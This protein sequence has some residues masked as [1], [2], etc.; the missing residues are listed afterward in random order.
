MAKTIGEQIKNQRVRKGLT[1]YRVA[2]DLHL[3]H[4]TVASAEDNKN[5]GIDFIVRIINYLGGAKEITI[6]WNEK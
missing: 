2:K 6:K 4:Q 3:R 1:I 5:V